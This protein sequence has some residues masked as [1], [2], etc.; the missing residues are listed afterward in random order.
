[1]LK[2]VSQ[3]KEELI[4]IVDLFRN[5]WN[6]YANKFLILAGI[7]VI[8]GIFYFFLKI[9]SGLSEVN[10]LIPGN[11]APFLIFLIQAVV[12][13][14]SICGLIVSILANSALIFAVINK[15]NAGFGIRESFAIAWR[16]FFSYAW[17][18]FLAGIFIFSSFFLFIIPGIIFF[19]WFAFSLF[20]F[21]DEGAKWEKGEKGEGIKGLNAL[22]RSKQLVK[23]YW[24]KVFWRLLVLF[25]AL[26]IAMIFISFVSERTND[27][28]FLSIFDILASPFVLVFNFLIYEN[29]KSLK[30][31]TPFIA[32]SKKTK[33]KF[34]LICL[35]GILIVMAVILAVIIFSQIPLLWLKLLNYG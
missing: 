11:P 27:S 26:F 7:A 2:Q 9:I 28:F 19:V 21:A 18:S 32:P 25:I 13:L 4:G 33:I 29:L 14:L 3:K 20:A 8:P 17:V 31:N 24:R 22:F 30:T 15:D 35:A 10:F 34:I 6:I 1:M 5:A 16:N 23:G 12:F